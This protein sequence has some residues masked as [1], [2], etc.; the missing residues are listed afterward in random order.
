VR[1]TEQHN[2]ITCV[3]ED[4]G[5]GI[6]ESERLKKQN[7]VSHHSLGLENLRKR[8]KIINEKYDV[9]CSLTVTDLQET[10]EAESGTRVILSL[11]II[12]L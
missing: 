7:R 2:R 12:N 11:N 5:I 1:F 10:Q 6:R 3:V 4:N 8:I 9:D